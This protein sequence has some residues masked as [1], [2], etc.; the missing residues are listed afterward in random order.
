MNHTFC[1]QHAFSISLYDRVLRDNGVKRNE[2]PWS[3]YAMLTVSRL[4]HSVIYL[5]P[6]V[7]VVFCVAFVAQ[8]TAK[9]LFRKPTFPV[10]HP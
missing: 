1:V 6:G 8:L 2:R 3:C 9:C 7:F 4:Q 10:T 5:T